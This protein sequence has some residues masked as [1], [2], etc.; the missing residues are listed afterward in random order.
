[1]RSFSA[2]GMAMC[3]P[4]LIHEILES[5][6]DKFWLPICKEHYER[7]EQG[8]SGSQPVYRMILPSFFLVQLSKCVV[9]LCRLVIFVLRQRETISC[10]DGHTLL[11]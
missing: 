8:N 3:K 10:W 1:M 2:S 6:G 7:I 5:G 11:E 9:R 4:E